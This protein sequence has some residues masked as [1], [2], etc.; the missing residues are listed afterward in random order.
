M[1]VLHVDGPV[2]GKGRPR[3]SRKTGRVYTDRLTRVAEDR[4]RHAWE[5]EG[6]P[7]VEGPVE[8]E[9]TAVLA[10]P[11][12]HFKRD[13][14][15]S[16]AGKRSQWPTKTPDLDNAVKIALDALNRRAFTD[17]AQIVILRAVKRWAS[18]G[19]PEHLEVRIVGIPVAAC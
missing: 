4:V 16:A 3:F 17:D 5:E 14:E 1:I 6:R 12:S 15:L 10:R 13:G 7:R 18:L 8:M 19:E 11:G 2:R 9:V